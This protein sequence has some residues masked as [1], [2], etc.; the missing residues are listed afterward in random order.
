MSPG[1]PRTARSGTKGTA[2]A[3][4]RRRAL[5]VALAAL[6]VV[7]AALATRPTDAAVPKPKVDLQVT[8]TVSAAVAAPGDPLTYT[9]EVVNHGPSGALAVVVEDV[10]P[11]AVTVAAVTS[12]P[13]RTC[14]VAPGTVTCAIGPMLAGNTFTLTID[15][16]VAQG[17]AG[18]LANVAT[19]RNDEDPQ[20]A[21]EETDP[22]NN[23][24]TVLTPIP[25]PPLPDPARLAVKLVDRDSTRAVE[26]RGLGA[27]DA[28]RYALVVINAGGEDGVVEAVRIDLPSA[29]DLAVEN[30]GQCAA[31][32]DG[33]LTCGRLSVPPGG[34]LE[35]EVAVRVLTGDPAT[36]RARATA[37][38]P[39]GEELT[40]VEPTPVNGGEDAPPALDDPPVELHLTATPAS[41]AIRGGEVA[42]VVLRL[43]NVSDVT[44]TGVAVAVDVP[45]GL[46]LLAGPAA[47]RVGTVPAG[48]TS[49]VELALRGDVAGGFT[50]AAEVAA[51][52]QADAESSYGDGMGADRATAE[53]GVT[54][55]L[56]AE[57]LAASGIVFDDEDADGV[58]D[59]GEA[60]M[61]GIAVQVVDAQGT[62][63]AA[64][65]TD[66]AGRYSLG[67]VPAGHTVEVLSAG[68]VATTPSTR[69]VRAGAVNFGLL[70]AAQDTIPDTGFDGAAA[71]AAGVVLLAAGAALVLTIPRRRRHR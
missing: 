39:S 20:F 43:E 69:F 52:D 29:A 55:V 36:L 70:A 65:L 37:V 47:W 22:D 59:P 64:A 25:P 56:A 42:A 6:A 35:L 10:L 46:S 14:D 3:I 61:R 7:A 45:P 17:A 24:S 33:A 16:T 8:K 4:Q 60:G 28:Y 58:A 23:T 26:P 1:G 21:P 41:Q 32:R 53:V 13:P 66:G 51:A 44:A 34:T 67:A 11:A 63:V 50:V 57:L 62:G 18:E 12:A 15:V 2:T 30:P 19:V 31:G 5:A 68:F 48:G 27:G 49:A 9:V 38:L 71:A 40:D 54:R